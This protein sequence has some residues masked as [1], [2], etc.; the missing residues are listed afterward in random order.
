LNEGIESSSYAQFHLNA[1]QAALENQ[2]KT[3][4]SALEQ[5]A[6]AVATAELDFFDLSGSINTMESLLDQVSDELLETNLDLDDL[7]YGI[8]SHVEE[9]EN[10]TRSHKELT[11]EEDKYTS[12]ISDL[13]R[14][15]TAQHQ[16]I[17]GATAA[18]NETK[19]EL[20]ELNKKLKAAKIEKLFVMADAAA[21]FSKKF[22]EQQGECY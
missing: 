15:A 3:F 19:E 12:E 18:M 5:S 8:N 22:E 6:D 4:S 14:T 10:L 21:R 9:L 16:A 11:A 1:E 13:Y 2:L 17:T 7:A 20:D